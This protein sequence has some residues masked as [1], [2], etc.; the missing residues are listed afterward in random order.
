MGNSSLNKDGAVIM[1]MAWGEL[2]EAAR[3]WEPGAGT[4]ELESIR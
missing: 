3:A 2:R 1:E 4:P